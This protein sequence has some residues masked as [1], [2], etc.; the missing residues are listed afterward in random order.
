MTCKKQVVLIWGYLYC[1]GC[2]YIQ[3]H[4]LNTTSSLTYNPLFHVILEYDM[5]RYC[6]AKYVSPFDFFFLF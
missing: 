6:V 5:N 3:T 1:N 4:L 2:I